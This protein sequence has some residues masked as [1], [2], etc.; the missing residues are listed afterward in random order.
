MTLEQI[1]M[2]CHEA[3]KA[4]CEANNDFSQLPW[5]LTATSSKYATVKGVEFLLSNPDAGHTASHDIWCKSMQDK[6]WK[7][8][9]VKDE[10]LKTN[11]SLVPYEELSP[12]Q[13]AKDALFVAI[14]RALS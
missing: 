2:V 12:L 10:T 7:Y 9:P 4:L 3:N 1:A 8:G 6:G 14:V 11:P 5:D 13:K